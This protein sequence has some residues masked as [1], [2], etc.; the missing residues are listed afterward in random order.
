ML[1]KLLLPLLQPAAAQAANAELL[2]GLPSKGRATWALAEAKL[3]SGKSSRLE[4]QQSRR[5]STVG[6]HQALWMHSLRQ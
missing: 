1:T 5:L 2:Q 6:A 3:G 4:R